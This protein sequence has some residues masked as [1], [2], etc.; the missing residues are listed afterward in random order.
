[1]GSGAGS[2]TGTDRDRHTTPPVTGPGAGTGTSL[3]LY[4]LYSLWL[5]SCSNS[6]TVQHS[7]YTRKRRMSLVVHSLRD[8][9]DYASQRWL[10]L[11]RPQLRRHTPPRRR[12]HRRSE[13]PQSVY[14]NDTL[15]SGAL[16]TDGRA[17]IGNRVTSA[18][19][20]RKESICRCVPL[21]FKCYSYSFRLP[22]RRLHCPASSPLGA[23]GRRA[24]RWGCALRGP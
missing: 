19:H 21:R 20:S 10:G 17:F 22:R 7:H 12:S 18:R 16:G 3:D 11:N 2:G 8:I 1:M 13:T 4:L 9:I 6:R 24:T 5:F 23:G 15:A 14:D